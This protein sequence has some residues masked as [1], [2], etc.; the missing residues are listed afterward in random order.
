MLDILV[1]DAMQR[2]FPAI[3]PEQTL[4]EALWTLHRRRLPEA[5]VL[6][7]GRCT[8]MFA[9]R[10]LMEPLA[11]RRSLAAKLPVREFTTPEPP[12]AGPR[13]PLFYALQRMLHSDARSMPV[14]DDAGNLVGLL[15]L[16]RAV[17]F[18]CDWQ[19]PE[20]CAVERVLQRFV[21]AVDRDLPLQEAAAAMRRLHTDCLVL[22]TGGVPHGIL[23]ALD[24]SLAA[25]GDKPLDAMGFTEAMRS[26]VLTAPPQ[27]SIYEVREMMRS[28]GVH[29]LVVRDRSGA[30]LGL[31]SIRDIA[32]ALEASHLQRITAALEEKDLRLE[33]LH[34]ENEELRSTLETVLQQALD[35]GLVLTD[36]DLKV[37]RCNEAAAALL[38]R[39]A[40]ELLGRTVCQIHAMEGLD[41][42][43]PRR[44]LGSLAPGESHTYEYSHPLEGAPHTFKARV[45]GIH[46]PDGATAGYLHMIRDISKEKRAEDNIHFLAFHDMLTGLPNRV[47]L[48]ERFALET[49]RAERKQRKVGLM[50]VDVNNFKKINDSLGHF[51]GDILLQKLARR[52]QGC[53][54]KSDTVARMGGDEFVVL[55]PEIRDCQDAGLVAD[56]IVSAMNEPFTVK[57][58]NVRISLSIGVCLYPDHGDRLGELLEQAD[59]VM[60]QA[61]HSSRASEGSCCLFVELPRPEARQQFEAVRSLGRQ[62]PYAG[63]S[64]GYGG[65]TAHKA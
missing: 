49:M 12:V 8:G 20:T 19:V 56:K 11:R 15:P 34:R 3:H 63:P 58:A 59:T 9:P 27:A 5:P 28:H 37:Q 22:L 45:Y 50:V 60:Y 26:P 10:L 31:V 25:M 53:L 47:S 39:E 41:H 44:M 17:H 7:A 32:R 33:R 36:T 4:G 57:G 43:G 16:A 38:G 46:T 51:S 2:E 21:P 52:L 54:R 18:L 55:L 1:Q 24:L 64:R 40:S 13:T 61:K 23:T 48:E 35:L 65:A 30:V 62:A 6:E 29:R 42:A 14:L